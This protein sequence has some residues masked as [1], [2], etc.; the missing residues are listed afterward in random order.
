MG[1]VGIDV[2]KGW[3]SNLFSYGMAWCLEF[4]RAYIRLMSSIVELGH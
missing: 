1:C 4:G 2:V 3:A